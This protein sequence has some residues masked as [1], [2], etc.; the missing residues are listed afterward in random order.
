M[1]ILLLILLLVAS[2]VFLVAT[3]W[4]YVAFEYLLFERPIDHLIE[5]D[6]QSDT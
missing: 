1:T 4:I 5:T 2:V 6:Q 3:C